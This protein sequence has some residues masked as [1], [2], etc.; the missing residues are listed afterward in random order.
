MHLTRILATGWI[1]GA[2]SKDEWSDNT[3]CSSAPKSS[4]SIKAVVVVVAVIGADVDVI[5]ASASLS[6]DSMASF[7]SGLITTSEVSGV[8]KPYL[9]NARRFLVIP[10]NQRLLN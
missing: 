8:T 6:S 5:E 4:Y 2:N 7:S 1:S 3:L 10:R 9:I